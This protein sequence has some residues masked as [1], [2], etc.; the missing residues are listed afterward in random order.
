[1]IKIGRPKPEDAPGHC[2]YF[3]NRTRED[4]LIDSLEN[5]KKLTVDL[6]KIIPSSLEEYRYAEGKWTVKMVFSHVIDAERLYC[7]NAMLFS[8]KDNAA[9]ADWCDRDTCAI[10]ANTAQRSLSEISDEFIAV[11]EATIRLFSY[12]TDEMLDFSNKKN[13]F[14][15]TARSLGWMIAG[16]NIHHCK[17]IEEKYLRKHKNFISENLIID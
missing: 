15:Y 4:N 6:I 2:N 9:F 14:I 16:H 5:S 7:F 11:R 10:N 8:R 3:F 12:M 1:M 13:N 17:L